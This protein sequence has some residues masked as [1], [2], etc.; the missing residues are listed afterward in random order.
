MERGLH[1]FVLC[2]SYTQNSCTYFFRVRFCKSCEDVLSY[3]GKEL[4]VSLRIFASHPSRS[5]VLFLIFGINSVLGIGV[6]GDRSDKFDLIHIGRILW[7][8]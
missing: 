1:S 7:C 4:P 8:V 3:C 2:S 6:N 5:L